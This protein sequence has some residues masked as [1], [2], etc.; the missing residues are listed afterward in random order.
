MR[1]CTDGGIGMGERRWV[2]IGLT[3]SCVEEGGGGMLGGSSC[4][5][6]DS[7]VV[8]VEVVVEDFLSDDCVDD[9]SEAVDGEVEVDVEPAAVAASS[10]DSFGS[11][12]VSSPNSLTNFNAAFLYIYNVPHQPLFLFPPPKRKTHLINMF[13]QIPNPT[14]STIILDQHIHRL[15]IQLYVCSTEPRG[16]LCLWSQITRSDDRFFLRYVSGN[17]QNLHT[18]QERRRDGVEVIGCTN[19]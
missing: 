8:A 12:N 7:V 15:R 2:V 17:F 5:G 11:G 9:S 10:S 6:M 14:L 16:F 19:E 1:T 4:E 3:F 13:L 18:V